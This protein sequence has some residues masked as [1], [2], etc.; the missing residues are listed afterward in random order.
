M[1]FLQNKHRGWMVAGL[2]LLLVAIAA[3][4]GEVFEKDD[5]ELLVRNERGAKSRGRCR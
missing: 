4:E 1:T 3:A 2:I 5:H